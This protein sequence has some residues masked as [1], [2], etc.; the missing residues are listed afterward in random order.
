MWKRAALFFFF[1]R[2]QS[3]VFTSFLMHSA[4]VIYRELSFPC[5]SC[6][7]LEKFWAF[8]ILEVTGKEIIPVFSG[9][10]RLLGIFS[11]RRRSC[12][13][14]KHP[15]YLFTLNEEKSL[16]QN[17]FI[18]D[19]LKKAWPFQ[20]YSVSENPAFLCFLAVSMHVS[21]LLAMLAC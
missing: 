1:R 13:S 16:G 8:V 20:I 11:R 17:F 12:F 4:L 6:N 10:R 3:G 15:V 21:V 9:S 2:Q 14:H 7:F 5:C 18:C 19:V